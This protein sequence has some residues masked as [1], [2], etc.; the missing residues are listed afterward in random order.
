MTCT[1]I[2]IGYDPNRRLEGSGAPGI[3]DGTPQPQG[4]AQCPKCD[5]GLVHG[6][7]G[8]TLVVANT[9][10]PAETYVLEFE[11]SEQAEEWMQARAVWLEDPRKIVMSIDPSRVPQSRGL[12]ESK[13]TKS[14]PRPKQ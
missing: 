3:Y 2:I 10:R 12:P 9:N 6:F 11:T 1:V 8:G 14:K 4:G 7:D 13:A 5:H